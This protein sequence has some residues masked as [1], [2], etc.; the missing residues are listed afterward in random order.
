M[1]SADAHI[2]DL[3][4]RQHGVVSRRQLLALG[5]SRDAIT[6]RIATGRLHRVHRGVY[7]VGHPR[8]PRDGHWM[9]AVLACGAG[10]VL[11]HRSAAALWGIREYNGRP[12][13]TVPAARRKN[14]L[15]IARSSQLQP[16]EVTEVRGI[17]TT[18]VARTILDL[19]AVLEH[20]HQIDKA[21]RQAEYLRLFDTTGLEALLSRHP[22]RKGTPRLR[23]A[24]ATA[25]AG[26]PH[27][28]SDMEDRFRA[29]VLK[30]NLPRPM[31]NATIQLEQETF[32]VDAHW[33]DHD[34]MV[35]L[36]SRQ[37][38]ETTAAFEEDRLR[39][40]RLAAHGY[41][42]VRITW[43]QLIASPQEVIADLSACMRRLSGHPRA[44]APLA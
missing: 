8:L 37:A 44:V 7:A 32:E 22:G 24:L 10:A 27:T 5:L 21:I 42:V 40:R 28:R 14:P 12:E 33:P 30:A 34:L 1:A 38:H 6:R 11:S 29:L 35:E 19:A 43:R 23:A 26:M 31:L 39:D 17:P 4:A 20:D 15:F 16:D 36:D 2:A 41:T 25:T 3:A 18:T 9:A 13:V